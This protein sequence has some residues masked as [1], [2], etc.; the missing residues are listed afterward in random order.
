MQCP[1]CNVF[2]HGEAY[3][4]AIALDKKYGEGTAAKL[5][6]RRFETH[7]FTVQ[8]LLDIIEEAKANLENYN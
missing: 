2:K 8:E 4:Y 1:S 3:E 7:K 6:A 5:H